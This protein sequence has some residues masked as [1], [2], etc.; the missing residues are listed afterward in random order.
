MASTPF[1]QGIRLY[2]KSGF[3]SSRR[4][5]SQSS[6]APSVDKLYALFYTYVD[7][8]VQKRAPHRAAHL[9]YAQRFVE[10]GRLVA[11]GA[12]EDGSGG[13]ILLRMDTVDGAHEFARNDPYVHAGL[14][15]R[16]EVRPWMVV[17]GTA[18][19]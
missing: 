13:M 4:L 9:A 6:V 3:I 17:V 19:K 14:V 12:W 8:V 7:G 18:K 16:H 11:G 15:V 10:D 5:Y 1:A 2:D